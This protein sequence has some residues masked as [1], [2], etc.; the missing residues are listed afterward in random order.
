M[1]ASRITLT[2]RGFRNH[3]LGLFYEKLYQISGL[4]KALPMNSG[5]EAV[6]RAIK[7]IR[8]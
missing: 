1:K 6:E 3:Q 8:K 7:A 5:A 2:S 4:I